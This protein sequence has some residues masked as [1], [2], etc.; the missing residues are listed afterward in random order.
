[1]PPRTRQAAVP[2][3]GSLCPATRSQ[4]R[5]WFP[6][7]P[8]PSSALTTPSSR[9]HGPRGLILRSRSRLIS[10][11]RFV[12]LSAVLS[13]T[14]VNSTPPFRLC[15]MYRLVVA[16]TARGGRLS[17]DRA[18]RREISNFSL[19]TFRPLSPRKF[20]EIARYTDTHLQPS[21]YALPLRES[22]GP[23]NA[24]TRENADVRNDHRQTCSSR[25]AH[26]RSTRPCVGWNLCARGGASWRDHCHHR[27]RRPPR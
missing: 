14:W 18:N 1:M 9:L 23:R 21:L 25:P 5:S 24:T 7:R 4:A 27:P 3:D 16:D 26:Q 11:A 22:R 17:Y 12:P 15:L 6:R 10:F 2:V 8:T 13:L 20:A 19:S